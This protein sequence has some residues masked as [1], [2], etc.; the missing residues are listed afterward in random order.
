MDLNPTQRQRLLA[1]D[2]LEAASDAAQARADRAFRVQLRAALAPQ[3]VPQLA[4]AVMRA[5][6]MEGPSFGSALRAAAGPAPALWPAVAGEIGVDVSGVGA[7]L[8]SALRQAASNPELAGPVTESVPVPSVA[9]APAQ[10]W[11]VPAALVAIAAGL[12]L[13]FWTWKQ[14]EPA[15]PVLDVMAVEFD[16]PGR[17]EIESLESETAMV[18]QVLQFDDDAPTIIFVDDTPI[19]EGSQ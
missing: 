14:P 5:L 16:S 1:E 8:G 6:G 2:A 3:T 18:V 17:T 7:L 13:A 12:L 15:A 11:R 10:K 19:E 4:P 9:S